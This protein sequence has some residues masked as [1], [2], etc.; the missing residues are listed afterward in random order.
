M[1]WLFQND[2][3][4]LN[5]TIKMFPPTDHWNILFLTNYFLPNDSPK[6]THLTVSAVSFFSD[7]WEE[8]LEPIDTSKHAIKIYHVHHES[9]LVQT[10]FFTTVEIRTIC[11]VH[12]IVIIYS[13]G[14]RILIY[15]FTTYFIMRPL[16]SIRLILQVL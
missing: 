14:V 5:F 10:C 7:A 12:N 6:F 15:N 9:P 8:K 4:M 11:F 13:A 16:Y 3:H 2:K 1:C